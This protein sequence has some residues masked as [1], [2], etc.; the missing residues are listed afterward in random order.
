ME[1]GKLR[2]MKKRDENEKKERYQNRERKIGHQEKE[3]GKERRTKGEKVDSNCATKSNNI[4]HQAYN[5]FMK[6]FE[7]N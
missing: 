6:W 4:G 5:L 7:R 2:T 1:S 3:Q